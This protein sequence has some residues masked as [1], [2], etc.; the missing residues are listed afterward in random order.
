M[1]IVSGVPVGDRVSG[2]VVV[3]NGSGRTGTGSGSGKG[4]QEFV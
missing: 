1:R 3:A 4:R 2:T